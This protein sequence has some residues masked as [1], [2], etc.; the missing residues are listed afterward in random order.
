[1]NNSI[2][3]KELFESTPEHKKTVFLTFLIKMMLIF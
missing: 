3:C 2:Y 1:M